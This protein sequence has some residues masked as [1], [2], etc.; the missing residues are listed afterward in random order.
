MLSRGATVLAW[1]FADANDPMSG[2]FCVRRERLVEVGQKAA[3]YKIGLEVLAGSNTDLHVLE[4]PITFAQRVE[5]ESKLKASTIY[6][7][8]DRLLALSGGSIGAAILQRFVGLTLVIMFIDFLLFAV[9]RSLDVQL[10]PSHIISFFVSAIAAY[11]LHVRWTIPDNAMPTKQSKIG[12]IISYLILSLLALFL[13]G[14]L[15]G[16]LVEH[17]HWHETLAIIPS[18][19]VSNM[20]LL[21]VFCYLLF[22]QATLEQNPWLRWRVATIGCLLYVLALKL[23]YMGV[24]DL[25]P[26]EAYYWNYAKHL[27]LGYLDHPPMVAWLI[28]LGTAIFGNTELG[29]RIGSLFCWLVTLGFV[30]RLAS[31]MYDKSTAMRSVLLVTVLPFFFM[32]GFLMTP[33]APLTACWAGTLFYLQRA[34]LR[35]QHKA[36]YAA[37]IFLGLGMLSKY[38]IALIAPAALV[39]MLIDKRMRR[40]LFRMEPYLAAMIALL[41]FTPVLVWNAQHNWASFVFQGPRR[42]ASEVGFSEHILLGG[43]AVLLTPI[44]LMALLS[45]WNKQ[46][47]TSLADTFNKLPTRQFAAI[48]TLI[49]LSVFV[50]FSFKHEPKLN[51]TGPLWLAVIPLISHAIRLDHILHNT[52]LNLAT[53]VQKLWQP[54]LLATLLIMSGLMHYLV[55]GLPGI[56]YNKQMKL[57]VAWE[58]MGQLVEEVEESVESRTHVEPLVV[59]LDKYFTASQVAFYRNKMSEH[60]TEDEINEGFEHT[61][62]DHLFDGTG[63]MYRYWFPAEDQTGRVLLLVSRSLDHLKDKRLEAY[64]E[65]LS[66]IE[67]ASITKYDKPVGCFYYRVGNRYHIPEVASAD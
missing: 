36:W 60:E 16:N 55:L 50:Y 42:M 3:G 32:T 47:A 6:Q 33:D 56:G 20:V 30:Y 28:A 41:L 43:I 2:F 1:P 7:Y 63:L 4:V 10:G 9:L 29:V 26:E 61:T 23:V 8:L 13:R 5:G 54:T 12:R 51:W 59:G 24:I 64:F 19:L 27:S 62:A 46:P 15:L 22:P 38:T 31:E 65:S 25:I 37:G 39:M 44:G 66:P 21:G 57:P 45:A 34:L 53:Q 49:P 18:M 11:L 58:E 48:F 52:R 14:G 17:G 40:Q 67:Q 35:D